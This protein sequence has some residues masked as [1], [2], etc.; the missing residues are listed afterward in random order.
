M[1]ALSP[2]DSP[3]CLPRRE[4]ALP[5]ETTFPLTG[6]RSSRVHTG[7]G[8]DARVTSSLIHNGKSPQRT[9]RSK[10]ASGRSSARATHLM[11][12]DRGMQRTRTRELQRAASPLIT[13]MITSPQQ[14]CAHADSTSK[15]RGSG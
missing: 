6:K 9:G 7:G 15:V 4:A 2:Q 14:V 5:V 3:P 1:T 13:N 11:G 12:G 10:G 8:D